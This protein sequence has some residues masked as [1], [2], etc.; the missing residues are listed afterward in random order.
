MALQLSLRQA[1]ELSELRFEPTHKRVRAFAG[2]TVF[3]DSRHAALVWEP[4]RVVP[5]YAFPEPDIR[6]ALTPAEPGEA[7]WHPVSLGAGTNVLTPGT[8]FG[9]HTAAGTSLTLT[10]GGVAL[11]GA[12]F[13]PDD[14]DLAGYVIV[15][16][17][18]FDQWREED[19]P[20]V[21]HPRDPFHRVDVRRSSRHVLVE[22]GGVTLAETGS[23]LL[24]FETSLPPRSYLPPSDVD[25]SR[26]RVS[27][28]QTACAYKGRARY[29][30]A[31]AAGTTYPDLAWAYEDPLPDAAQLAGYV[32]FFDEH[33]DVT[34]DGERVPRP[35]TPWS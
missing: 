23:P 19:E 1:R 34:V 4:R 9:A 22:V 17:A 6:A 14:P 32:A 24:V 11:E 29:F 30:S 33:V 8:G 31:E 2:G 7:A 12:G 35:V 3:A 26:L 20:I 10:L 13:R 15:D 16:F 27:T 25:F 18:A 21:A 28:R 5:Q